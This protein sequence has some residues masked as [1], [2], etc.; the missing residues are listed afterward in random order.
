MTSIEYL[1]HNDKSTSKYALFPLIKVPFHCGSDLVL[2][3]KD[4]QCIILSSMVQGG[5]TCEQ[6]VD[7]DE[8]GRPAIQRRGKAVL[9]L[10]KAAQ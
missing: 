7:N 6:H 3:Y 1:V 5:S 4:H 2:P 8:W 10:E 9:A